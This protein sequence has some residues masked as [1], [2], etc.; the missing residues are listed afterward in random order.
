MQFEPESGLKFDGTLY[1]NRA[2]T[3]RN[4]SNSLNNGYKNVIHYSDSIINNG[5]KDARAALLAADIDGPIILP[6]GTYAVASN[7]T[8]ANKVMFLPGAKLKP[9]SGVVV[10]LSGGLETQNKQQVFD[11]SASGTVN[12]SGMQDVRPDWWG[13]NTTTSKP[14][15]ATGAAASDTWVDA[16]GTTAH[17]P[18]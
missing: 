10:T 3:K 7:L 4:L 17:T 16:T 9:A 1:N 13:A 15:Y 11:E 18:V 6:P 14:V 5:V 2:I 12:V 8:I